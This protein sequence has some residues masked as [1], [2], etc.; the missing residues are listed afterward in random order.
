V[1]EA[2]QKE[3]V[4][5][6]KA[7]VSLLEALQNMPNRSD[8]IR[9]AILSA[10]QNHCPLCRGT[11]LL[12]PN[13]KT[14]WETFLQSHALRKCDEC[15]EIHLVCSPP[16]AGTGAGRPVRKVRHRAAEP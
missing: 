16:E 1:A 14:H 6:F 15:H 7:D 8:F 10:L 13:Q 3:C 4:I 5:T 2:K 12:T 11:G 9:A